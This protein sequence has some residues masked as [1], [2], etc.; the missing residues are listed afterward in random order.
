MIDD[1]SCA[2]PGYTVNL[3]APSALNTSLALRQAI[4]TTSDPAW[5]MCG[6]PEM[7]YVDHGSDFIRDHL[8]RSRPILKF[9]IVHSTVA[10]PQGRGK[11]ERLFASINTELLTELPGHLVHGKPVTTPALSLRELDEAIGRYITGIYHP[12]THSEI[13][14]SSNTWIASASTTPDADASNSRIIARA[15]WGVTRSVS[16]CRSSSTSAVMPIAS[17]CPAARVHRIYPRSG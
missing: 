15:R 17:S 1:C 9:A 3:G 5:P 8:A 10:R 13:G 2:V 4:W 14:V 6:T 11:V 12:R 16:W 7:L